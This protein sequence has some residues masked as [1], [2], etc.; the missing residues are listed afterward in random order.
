MP[1]TKKRP[2]RK[3]KRGAAKANKDA[4]EEKKQEEVPLTDSPADRLRAAGIVATYSQDSRG[5]HANTKDIHVSNVTVTYFG[6]PLIEEADV[7]FNYGNRYGFIGRNGCGK[8]TF[9]KLLGARALPI[10]ENIDMFYLAEEIEAGEITP[11]EAVMAVDEERA[12][13]EKEQDELQ[14]KLCEDAEDEEVLDRLNMVIER[15]EEMDVSTA[16]A[17]ASQ[18]LHGLG[19]TRR[20]QAMKTREF[21]GGWR[22]RI[23]LARALFLKPTLLLMDEPTNHLDMEAVVWLENY[24]K[25]WNKILFFC[26]HSQDFLN[27]VCTHMVHLKDK[28]LT[29]Y[30]GN[31]DMFV[32]TRQEVEDNQM[33]RYNYEQDQIKQMKNYIAKFGHGSAKLARQA[34]SKEKTLEKMIRG[35]LT[36]KVAADRAMDFTFPDPGPLPP[37]VL[38][39]QQISFAYPDSPLL[40]ENVD[41]GVDLDSRMAL[42]GPNGAGKTTFLKMLMGELVPTNGNIKTHSHLRISKF[43]QHFV[44]ILDEDK[45]PLDYFMDIYPDVPRDQ[46]RSYLGRYGVT[47]SVQTQL[48]KH[49]SDGQKSR[50][51]FAKMAKETPHLL[52]LDEPTNHLDMESID[53]LARAITKFKGGLVLVSHD[54]RLISQVAQE[55]WICDQKRVTRYQGDIADFK[56]GIRQSQEAGTHV[57]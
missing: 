10:P 41:F 55:I 52:L 44:D 14:E 4:V 12:K 48:I 34:Q 30:S 18:I 54:M 29:Y 42:V 24:L 45:S 20:M 6:K 23:S 2:A 40:Y 47:G 46:A 26:C 39:V 53:S 32:Q 50:V 22:M 37:P 27:E 8:T 16:E 7:S 31:Y 11:L 38:Q 5:M 56:L 51:V 15:L 57:H 17:R 25:H 19:F 35:G 28:K 9:L 33:K 13:L 3:G 21:S 1:P 49:L 43:T 36:E